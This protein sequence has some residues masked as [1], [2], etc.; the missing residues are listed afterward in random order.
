M[1]SPYASSR[2][3]AARKLIRIRPIAIWALTVLLATS[4]LLA[5]GRRRR[6]LRRRREAQAQQENVTLNYPT[7][8]RSEHVDDY[9]G[10]T[11]ADPYRWLENVDSP[12]SRDWI[13]R[14]NKVTFGYL[15]RLPQREAYRKRLTELWNY[16]RFGAPTK[17][18]GRYFFSHNDGLQNQSVLFVAESL[19]AEPRV[20]LD[21]NT[22]SEDGT[23]ALAGYRVSDDGKR[24][25]Y[26]LAADGSDWREWKVIDIDSGK[27]LDDH[28]KWVKFS[29]VSWT[30]DNQGFYYSRYDEP[31]AGKEFTGAN[32][33]QK[34]YYHRVGEPQSKDRLV[35][36]RKDEKEWGFDG[37]VT[38]DGR[39]LIISVWRGTERKTQIFYRSLAEENSAVVELLAGFDAEYNV[40]GNRDGLLWVLTDL[41]A[42]NRR[43]I[44]IDTSQP[45]PEHWR[46]VIPESKH[47]LRGVSLV[48]GRF[49]A[50]YLEDAHS[51][52][53]VFSTDGEF[54]R[55]V[56][57]PGIG[58]AGGFSGRGD[59]PETYYVFSNYTTPSTV[60]RYD[61][62]TGESRV[63]RRPEVD[64]DPDAFE[65][66][67]V[68]FKSKDGT[69]VPMFITHKKG[70]ELNGDNPTIL[71][72]YGG[73][74]IS[75]TPSFSVSNLTWL[76]R[77]GVYAVAN[78]RGGGE[79]G[80]TWHEAGMLDRKQNVF[81]D[82][83]AA[84]EWLIENK[85]TQTKRLA[86]RG[87]SNGGLLVGAAITQRPE[88]YGAAVP[89]VGVMDMLRYHKF[90]IGWAW[91][92]E[93]GSSDDSQQFRNLRKYSPLHNLKPGVAY[94]PTLVTT[95]D[96][97]DRVVPSHSFKFAAQLQHAHAGDAPVLIRIE[98]SAG[99]GAGTPTSKL[100]ESAADALAFIEAATTD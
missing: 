71:Y 18:G 15:S 50:S 42:P 37:D 81:D 9:H 47:V 54:V 19:D 96:H 31:E 21:P 27:P 99:H 64:F 24:L 68:F 56:E 51:V 82:F 34:L 45:E 72:A 41:E 23:V 67:Q 52:M 85:Y 32:Y 17:K 90:T 100:I 46:E 79:Y 75:L 65:T 6:R 25:A 94:P 3:C 87:G 22:L 59:D 61:V 28:L 7:T 29:G 20:L 74:N 55:D 57:F 35:Y 58:S 63:H 91:V 62:A 43:L 80:R 16:E 33:H 12:K 78:L 44:A 5:D 2:Y 84:A 38:E 76:E 49:V 73:F 97:D 1:S 26:G 83:I 69:R 10:E 95:A 66:R 14:Q 93:Y 70:L 48:G 60:Y 39:Y 86:I 53:K 13:E 98:S 40:V 77:G 88:L 4:A 89:A 30:P 8:H 11:V 36:Q 92:S